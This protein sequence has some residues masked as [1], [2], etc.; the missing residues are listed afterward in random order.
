MSFTQPNIKSS[1]II[2]RAIL[3][4]LQQRPLKLVRLI[5]IEGTHLSCKEIGSHGNSLFSSLTLTLFNLFGDYKL[6]KY[7][8]R[9]QTRP[10]V[11]ICLQDHADEAPL[12]NIKIKCRRW[13][14]TPLISE[15][16]GTQ[17]VAMATKLVL[18]C[19]YCGAHVFESYCKESSI[20][21]TNWVAYLFPS[22]F[23]M[24]IPTSSL[25][26]FA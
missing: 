5:V 26:K 22:H 18:V 17:Y 2:V 8:E 1:I 12:A 16:S 10:N 9:Q 24:I 20:S 13:P 23:I 11:F 6:E 3:V 7:L 19:S 25:G 14:A 15:R 4:N 21:D